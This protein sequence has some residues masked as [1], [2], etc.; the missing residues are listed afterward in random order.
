[1]GMRSDDLRALTARYG[2]GAI[3]LRGR[4]GLGPSLLEDLEHPNGVPRVHG[5]RRALLD[6]RPDSL[7]EGAVV[8]TLEGD[9]LARVARA[10]AARP[11]PAASVLTEAAIAGPHPLAELRL[12][13]IQAVASEAGLHPADAEAGPVQRRDR[14]HPQV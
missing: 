4:D 11:E 14:A 6:P 12:L 7:V 2:A 1:M 5:R 3:V 13:R 8:A 10:R 9:P